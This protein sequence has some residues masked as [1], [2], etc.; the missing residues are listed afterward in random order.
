MAA[1]PAATAALD[2]RTLDAGAAVALLAAVAS[3][4]RVVNP[5]PAKF[6]P[7]FNGNV[8][9]ITQVGDTMVV[10][11]SFTS[12]TPV[13]AQGTPGTAVARTN[14][15]AFNAATGVINTG[16]N[17]SLSGPVQAVQPGPTAGTVFVGGNFTG[18]LKLL[19]LS[20]G[21]PTAGFTVPTVASGNVNDIDIDIIG[22]RLYLGGSFRK[23]GG[24]PAHWTRN[25][26][27]HYRRR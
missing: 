27:R 11:G 21:N 18:K 5:V 1:A 9:A 23:V 8:Y 19:N 10:G 22:N 14:I 2:A 7:Q 16:F 13:N 24:K 25:A 26:E 4:D 17:P 6:T 12:V 15:V 20:N 3:P